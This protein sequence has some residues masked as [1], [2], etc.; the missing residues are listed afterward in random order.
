MSQKAFLQDVDLTL[1]AYEQAIGVVATRTRQMIERYGAIDAFSR[2]AI[3][4]DLQS[5]FKALRD[6]N[7][8]DLTAEAVIVRHAGLFREDVVAAAN[9]RLENAHLLK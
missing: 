9:W 1:A 8:L 4:A 6:R 3:S 2:L 5:G 7:Q